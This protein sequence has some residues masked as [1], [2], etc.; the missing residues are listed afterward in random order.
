MKRTALFFAFAITAAV[1][2]WAKDYTYSVDWHWGIVNIHAGDV[3]VNLDYGDDLVNGALAGQSVPIR[4]NVMSIS[5]TISACLSLDRAEIN[6]INGVYSRHH[7]G[8]WSDQYRNIHGEGELDASPETMEAVAIT[9]MLP[10]FFYYADQL[11]FSKMEEGHTVEVPF[12]TNGQD[13]RMLIT[14]QGTQESDCGEAYSL[15]LV[16]DVGEASQYPIWCLVN[17]ADR[18]PILFAATLRI[19]HVQMALI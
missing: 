3:K 12:V 6:Y 2:G 13:G 8:V 18:T 7:D 11:D 15:S 17:A 4:G 19:G 1:L 9:A 14:Y 16:F 10:G 5:D